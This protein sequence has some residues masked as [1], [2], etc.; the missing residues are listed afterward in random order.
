MP[1]ITAT[2]PPPTSSTYL[3]DRGLAFFLNNFLAGTSFLRETWDSHQLRMGTTPLARAG[4]PGVCWSSGR[5]SK[6]N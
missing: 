5:T 3:P 1:K 6:N 2:Y 4:I